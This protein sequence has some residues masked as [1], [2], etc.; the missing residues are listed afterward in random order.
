MLCKSFLVN[1]LSE[2]GVAQHLI[3]QKSVSPERD[4]ECPVTISAGTIAHD[5]TK[6]LAPS[7]SVHKYAVTTVV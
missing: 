3:I 5:H 7:P 2:G 6:S 1:T 4:T